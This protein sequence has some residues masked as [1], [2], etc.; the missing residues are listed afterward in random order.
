MQ[1]FWSVLFGVVLLATFL[2]WFAAPSLGWWLPENV[3]QTGEGVDRLFFIILGFTAFFFVI[4]EVILVQAM[5]KFPAGPTRSR[6][7]HG[8]HRLELL[9]TVT[10]GIILLFIAFTQIG[11]WERMK[12]QSRMPSPDQ[13]LSVQARQWE[14]RMRYPMDSQQFAFDPSSEP[15]KIDAHRRSRSWADNPYWDDVHS[16]NELHTW[17]GANVKIWLRTLD[18][19]HSFTLPNLRLKQDTLPGKTIPMWFC[20]EKSNCRF[21]L[22]DRVSGK[23][24]ISKMDEHSREIKIREGEDWQFLTAKSGSVR[25]EMFT[26]GSKEDNW[27]I[28]CQELCGARHYAMRGRLWVHESEKSFQTWLQYQ[29]GEQLARDEISNTSSA[30]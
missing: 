10:P 16:V 1:K 21:V 18:V 13:T 27:E 12:Y 5:W 7:T 14:W 17:K 22:M 29:R 4:T 8:N 26:T 19:L 24:S 28:A 3:S 6:Y 30:K 23:V 9:W 20:A 25:G 2:V 15:D 11:V